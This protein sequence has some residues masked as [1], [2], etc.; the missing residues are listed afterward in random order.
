MNCDDVKELL[1]EYVD[2]TLDAKPKAL[3]EKHLST[4]KGCQ[5]EVV[6][7][8]ALISDLGSMESIAPPKDFLDQFH[9]R[10][11]QCSWFSRVFRNLLSSLQVAIGTSILLHRIFDLFLK[12]LHIDAFLC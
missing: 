7:L 11:E 3:V 2:E 8:R 4:C 1:S 9:K 10:M 12:I 6:S 5:Q